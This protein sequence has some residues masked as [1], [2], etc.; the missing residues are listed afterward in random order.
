MGT[1]STSWP[2]FRI[3]STT[4]AGL[5]AMG[6]KAFSFY[7]SQNAPPVLKSVLIFL[8]KSDD[9][10]GWATLILVPTMLAVIGLSNILSI[11]ERRRI[12]AA[13]SWLQE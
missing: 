11:R 1:I 12:Q 13:D 4:S 9:L 7:S 10:W 2:S 3:A 8:D 6:G 5:L